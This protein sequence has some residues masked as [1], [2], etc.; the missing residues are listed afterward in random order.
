MFSAGDLLEIESGT[1]ILLTNT[2][3]HDITLC[4]RVSLQTQLHLGDLV[5]R[6]KTSPATAIGQD[7]QV[8]LCAVC[9]GRF[10][11][12][13]K[14]LPQHVRQTLFLVDADKETSY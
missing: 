7:A 1:G 9:D 6:E 11:D 2:Q 3:H 14:C 8:A 10:K 13:D 5:V 12:A 4:D